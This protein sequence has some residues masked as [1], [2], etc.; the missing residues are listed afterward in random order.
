[1]WG[2]TWPPIPLHVSY[3]GTDGALVI[4]S[5]DDPS[6]HSSQ[7]EQDN[8]ITHAL[9]KSHAGTGGQRRS[10]GI[11]QARLRDERAIRHAGFFAI[12]HEGFPLEVRCRDFPAGFLR[13]QDIHPDPC[14]QVCH[15]AG[16]GENP[17][18]GSG[19]KDA[20][21]ARLCRNLPGKPHGNQ[22]SRGGYHHRR[23]PY[24]YAKRFSRTSPTSNW[25]WCT[26]CP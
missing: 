11:R 1:M 3:T 12:H 17:T 23:H 19:K 25:E 16:H 7:N 4:V 2:S 26:P 15:G 22:Q 18:R 13:G 6:L 21:P 10:Q 24:N 14:R 8:V 5:A 20:R 9:P